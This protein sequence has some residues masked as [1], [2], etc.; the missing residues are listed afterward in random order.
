MFLIGIKPIRRFIKDQHRRVMNQCL[1]KTG[2]LPKT[3]GES[4]NHLIFDIA[5][6]SHLDHN[7]DSSL[8]FLTAVTPDLA[9]K[10]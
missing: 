5:K 2:T 6:R 3:F 9:D 4:L 10:T 1:S 8:K 7:T